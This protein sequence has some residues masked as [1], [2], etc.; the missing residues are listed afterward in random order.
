MGTL[1]VSLLAL[2]TASIPT[3]IVGTTQSPSEAAAT[4]LKAAAEAAQREDCETTL[5]EVGPVVDGN[6]AGLPTNLLAAAFDLAIVC[7]AQLN[8][9][10]KTGQYAHRA[11]SLTEASDLAWR[12]RFSADYDAERYSQAVE[13]L[14]SMRQSRAALLNGLDPRWIWRLHFALKRAR[15]NGLDK[16]L[17][18]ILTAPLYEP[19]D[20][21]FIID[22]GRGNAKA[23][24]A[25]YYMAE[26]DRA[27]A[28]KLAAELSS[29]SAIT[30]ALFN[31]DL[32]AAS[33]LS[34]N[35]RV[36]AEADLNRLRDLKKRFPNSL[37]P[38]I[39]EANALR[40][41]G[42]PAD[43]IAALEL[44]R[45]RIE[46]SPPFDDQAENLPWWW[47]E[48]GYAHSMAGN[49]DAMVAS[50]TSGSALNEDGSPNVSQVINL[51]T[52]QVA[53]GRYDD[54]LRSVSPEFLKR[55]MSPFGKMQALS[56][57][58]C[59]LALSGKVAEAQ[60]VLREAIAHES[61]DPATVTDLRLCSGEEAEAAASYVKRLM[62]QRQ[63]PIAL[64]ELANYAKPA[65]NAPIDPR[66]LRRAKVALRP[67]VQK[68]LNAAG[69][70]VE[71]P[72]QR[73]SLGW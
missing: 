6:T 64:K 55:D 72:L 59:A 20:P 65:P 5:K 57:R 25:G 21:S 16:R 73:N 26:G 35:L 62:D 45:S 13:T 34:S 43:A 1:V 67:E 27:G 36:A 2:A 70:V 60:A 69:G 29:V 11:T 10:E 8:E 14:E 18:T 12:M 4:H 48:L 40:Q 22:D 54:A 71:V 44:A 49:Y 31:P 58:G 66:D 63:R 56:V 33:R 3:T 15:L 30:E 46:S 37:R 50:F 53:F 19:E 47:N 24:L 52:Q 23:I 39:G 32:R 51:G 38:L 41:L 9:I 28:L 7:N 17:L 61:D 68:A 42:R